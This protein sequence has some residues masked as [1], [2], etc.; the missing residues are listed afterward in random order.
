M[1]LT[2]KELDALK[3]QEKPYRV[4]YEK[5]LYLEVKPSGAKSWVFRFTKADGSRSWMGLGGYPDLGAAKAALKASKL[6]TG[7]AEGIDPLAAK[8]EKQQQKE[9]SNANTFSK[10]AE[11]WYQYKLPGWSKATAEKCRDYL[12]KDMLPAS[13]YRLYLLGL[14]D[15]P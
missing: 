9:A 2:V 11:E 12:D 3:P 14:S 4:L 6:R 8:R 15:F 10:V 13:W 7:I 5:G 1:P